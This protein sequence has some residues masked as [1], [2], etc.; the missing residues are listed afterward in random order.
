MMPQASLH[1]AD[2]IK[3]GTTQGEPLILLF[4]VLPCNGFA[5][6]DRGPGESRFGPTPIKCGSTIIQL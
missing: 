2:H 6:D 4:L 3:N 5:G 1:P